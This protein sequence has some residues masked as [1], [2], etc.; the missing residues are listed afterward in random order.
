MITLSACYRNFVWLDQQLSTYTKLNPNPNPINR[1][2]FP[3]FAE[4]VRCSQPE[5]NM[6]QMT[7]NFSGSKQLCVILKAFLRPSRQIAIARWTSC[8]VLP[9]IHEKW[10]ITLFTSAA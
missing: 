7:S 4:T 5:I 1:I 6:H 3:T 8:F 2:I 9:P 10:G